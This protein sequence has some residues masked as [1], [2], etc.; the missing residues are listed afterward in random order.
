MGNVPYWYADEVSGT[1][2][3]NNELM[4]VPK[5]LFLIDI[6]FQINILCSPKLTL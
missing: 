2:M 3:M 1:T 4:P 6:T 5:K